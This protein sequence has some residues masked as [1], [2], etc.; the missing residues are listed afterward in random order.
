MR[1]P[2]NGAM[3]VTLS[4]P[5]GLERRPRVRRKRLRRLAVALI[6]L[7]VALLAAGFWLPAR[8]WQ[9]STIDETTPPPRPQSGQHH[10]SL[11]AL[12]VGDEL[13][14]EQPD[15]SMH[16]YEVAGVDIIDSRHAELALDRDENVVVL[17]ARWPFDGQAVAGDWRYVVTA[18]QRF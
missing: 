13:T 15:G 2:W 18:R 17:V 12:T 1:R 16:A 8:A 4:L 7:C 6:A 11:A 10:R 5:L 9:R 14:L 3:P